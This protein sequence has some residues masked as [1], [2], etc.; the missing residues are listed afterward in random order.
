[1]PLYRLKT[2]DELKAM[3]GTEVAEAN[4]LERDIEAGHVH[5]VSFKYWEASL[6]LR[7]DMNFTW[8][9]KRDKSIEVQFRNPKYLSQKCSFTIPIAYLT[10]AI[11]VS[12][13]LDLI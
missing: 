12:K 6:D 1:M 3:Y 13:N 8:K 9:E 10:E 7:F 4:N 5:G 2:I 11:N